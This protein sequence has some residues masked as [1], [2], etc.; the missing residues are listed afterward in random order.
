MSWKAQAKFFVDKGYYVI[1]P[2]MRG[3]NTSDKPEGNNS[4]DCPIQTLIDRILAESAYHMDY[5]VADVI[6]L[7]DTF[8]GAN[9]KALV[10]PNL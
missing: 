5:L 8:A 6:T 4:L 7:I 10:S 9:N 1:I 3:Y 2:D